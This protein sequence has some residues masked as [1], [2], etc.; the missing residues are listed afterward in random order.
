MGN[1]KPIQIVTERWYSEALKMNVMTKRTDPLHGGTTIYKLTNISHD[2]PASSLFEIPADYTVKEGPM[3]HP[4][5]PAAPSEPAPQE[6][7]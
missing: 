1:D 6:Q 3:W 5:A 2:E 7:Q 4:K